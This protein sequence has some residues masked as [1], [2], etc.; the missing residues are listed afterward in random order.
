[1]ENVTRDVIADIWPLYVSGDV[2]PDTRK[3]VEAYLYED[4]EF[5]QTLSE[6]AGER[7]PHL[8]TPFLTPDH[9]LRTLTR[10]RR[11]LAG[12]VWL[13]QLALIFTC[14]AFGRLIS[15]TSFDVSPRKFIVAASVA[16]C[17][18]I[19]FFVVLYKGRRDI[20]FRVRR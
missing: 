8:Q 14:L 16:A 13:M 6:M 10:I 12:P 5:A 18:W 3:L 20:L 7:L 9:E 15:D 4:T 1:M 17:M 19:A 2:S 11:R